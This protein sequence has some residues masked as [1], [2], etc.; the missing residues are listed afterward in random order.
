VSY[1][2]HRATI[3]LRGRNL[4]DAEYEPVAGTTIRRLADPISAELTLRTLF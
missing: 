3:T 1:P 2:W 4:L